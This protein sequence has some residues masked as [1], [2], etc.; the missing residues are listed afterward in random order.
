MVHKRINIIIN[1]A[2]QQATEQSH[3]L[4]QLSFT[5]TQG[6]NVFTLEELLISQPVQC[7]FLRL[8]RSDIY[9]TAA[10]ALVPYMFL[11]AFRIEELEGSSHTSSENSARS[12]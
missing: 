2:S 5:R 10:Y 1:R 3:K 11:H 4:R 7:R 12:H 9:R 6:F 8:L